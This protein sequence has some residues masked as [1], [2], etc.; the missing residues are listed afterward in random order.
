MISLDYIPRY[1]KTLDNQ[2]YLDQDSAK[3][4]RSKLMESFKDDGGITYPN[5]YGGSYTYGSALVVCLLDVSEERINRYREICSFD[6]L[7]FE[8]VSYTYSKLLDAYYH[9]IEIMQKEDAVIAV[10]VCNRS[11]CVIVS[12]YNYSAETTKWDSVFKESYYCIEGVETKGGDTSGPGGGSTI[13]HTYGSETAYR[14]TSLTCWA[15]AGS[16]S[17]R[18]YYAVT[19]GH[20][21]QNGDPFYYGTAYLG[22]ASNVVTSNYSDVTIIE[23]NSST[24]SLIVSPVGYI[25]SGLYWGSS[26]TEV[27]G[28][29]DNIFLYARGSM[30]TG[31]V[32]AYPAA[33]KLSFNN[34]SISNALYC[35]YSNYSVIEGDSGGCVYT[36]TNSVRKLCGIQSH[37]DGIGCGYAP[38]AQNC[39]A[40]TNLSG[41][42]YSG[43]EP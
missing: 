10:R 2:S 35:S 24:A 15:Y 25:G 30:R 21:T 22:D 34:N 18:K 39:F 8:K 4:A 14:N 36:I 17:N 33:Y 3:L 43:N 32:S 19:S 41:V 9:A 29:G 40:S 38:L 23:Y 16:G 13:K 6:D 28:E 12:I 31:E 42:V 5:D 20:Y 37:C 7:Y 1:Y 26:T 27:P 11:N